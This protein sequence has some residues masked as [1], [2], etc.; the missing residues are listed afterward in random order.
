MATLLHESQITWARPHDVGYPHEEARAL[1]KNIKARIE[2]EVRF[3]Q[4]S[5]ALYATDASN[6]RQVPIGVVVPKTTEDVL[7]T[8]EQCR[9]YGAPLLARGGGTSL[10]GQCCNVAVVLDFTKHLN[11]LVDLD[12]QRK[13]ARVQ[14]GIV[15]DWLRKEAERHHL[16]F[17]PDPATHNHNTLGGMIGNNS[18]GTHS[19]MAGKTEENVIVLDVLTYDGLCLRVGA[20]TEDE[21]QRISREGGRRAEIYTGLRRIAEQHSE[22]IRRR[23]PNI[24]RRVSGYNLPELLPENGFHVARALVGT[25]CTCAVTLEATVKLVWSP[26]GRTLV[27]LGYPDIYQAGDHVP[28]ILE[29]RP[30]ACEAIDALLVE[31]MRIKGLHPRDLKL[32]PDGRGWLLVEFGGEDRKDSDDQA[33]RLMDS[34][35]KHGNTPAMK[36]YDDADEERLVWEIRESGLGATAWVPGE[37]VTWEGWE[38][39]AVAPDKV[40]PYLRDLCRLYE[41]HGY[42]GALYGHFGQ[43]CI[44]TRITFDLL[45]A[46]G[47]ANY[48]SFMDAATSL[49]VKYGGSLSGEH[50]DGQSKAEFLPKMF[51]AEVCEAFREFKSIWDPQGKMNPGK[52][53]DPYPITENL[54]LGTA[55]APKEPAT[56]FHFTNDEGSFTHAALRCVGI[57]ECRRQEKGTMCPSYRA[58]MEEKHSTRGRGHLLFEMMR[59]EVIRDGWKSEE[60]FDAL[61]LCLSCKGCKGDCPV[62]VDMATYKAEFLSHYYE[63]RLR[64]RSAYAMGW[65]HRWARLAAHAPSF[66][67]AAAQMPGAKWLAGIA[68]E[69]EM[70]R[71]APITFKEWFRRRG[72]RNV[73]K[74]EV[75]L[76]AD[77]FNNYFHPGVAAAAT[78]VLEDAGFRVL[79]PRPALCCGRPLYDYGFLDEADKLIGDILRGLKRWIEAGTPVVGL[80]PSCLAVFRDEMLDLRPHDHDARRLHSQ[81]FSLAEFLTRQGYQPPTLH[82]EVV[83]HGHCHQKAIIG[84]GAEKK[85]FEAMK[86][87]PEILD[88]GC[89]GMAGSFGFEEQKYDVSR[90]VYEH[91]LGPRLRGLPSQKLVVADGFSCKTQIEQASGR[92]P[93]HLAELLRM[94]KTGDG[95]VEGLD[96]SSWKRSTA[97]LL[98]GASIALGAWYLKRRMA[99]ESHPYDNTSFKEP[100]R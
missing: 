53:V 62:N 8:V 99:P 82:R 45:T 39:S 18:C 91:A 7:A 4:G 13:T 84:L 56:H 44:H 95:R 100:C 96:G 68:P 14:P 35:K 90:K 89:C 64:P 12:P 73:G 50:G 69:R 3:D 80:E 60:V 63:G 58:T 47:I 57:G 59:G 98:A 75:I 83:V 17:G 55:F 34:L 28:G 76:W 67:N 26:P 32:L 66:A 48:R 54:R 31:N 21:Y 41:K 85:L 52:I 25:E 72:T 51:G 29:F 37:H 74:P 5:R 86:A 33:R 24:P 49:V 23:F 2:G 16:T 6:Y 36:L 46:A 97:L 27:V 42:Q 71:F 20:T 30:I 93:L 88:D 22:E 87:E 79:V 11:K 77:T 10:A 1:E 70:P 78:E 94:A 92:R 19:V 15:L 81:V 9:R 38:D 65:I 61:D 40:G 43:G